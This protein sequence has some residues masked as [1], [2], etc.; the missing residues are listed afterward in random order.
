MVNIFFL[1]KKRIGSDRI[2]FFLNFELIVAY[3][4]NL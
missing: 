2:F 4:K 3:E 1:R